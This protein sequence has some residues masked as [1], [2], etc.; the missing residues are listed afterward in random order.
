MILILTN[1]PVLEVE[2]SDILKL[3]VPIKRAKRKR[4]TRSI[5]RKDNQEEHATMIHPQTHHFEKFGID[6]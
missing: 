1:I 6:L 2:N 5:R 4:V 3:I